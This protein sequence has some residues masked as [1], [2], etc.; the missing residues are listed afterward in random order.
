V[1][2]VSIWRAEDFQFGQGISPTP[3]GRVTVDYGSSRYRRIKLLL[4][5]SDYSLSPGVS[6]RFSLRPGAGSRF[7][8]G[9][10]YL[11]DEFLVVTELLHGNA[12]RLCHNKYQEQ[13]QV[14]AEARLTG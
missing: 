12:L 11:G 14:C 10:L 1:L 6:E 4:L 13:A 8:P 2:L 3:C 9:N 7:P 5:F